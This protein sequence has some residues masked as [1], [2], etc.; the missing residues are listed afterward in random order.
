MANI[1]T[2]TNKKKAGR[3]ALGETVVISLRIRKNIYDAMKHKYDKAW[4]ELFRDF[5]RVY[6]V[7][8][9]EKGEMKLK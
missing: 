1:R 6:C 9:D 8:E 4:G 3:P 2:E 5:L 7:I